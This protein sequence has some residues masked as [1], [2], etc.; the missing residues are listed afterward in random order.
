MHCEGNISLLSRHLTAAS[1]GLVAWRCAGRDGMAQS[2]YLKQA[3]CSKRM[4]CQEEAS[5][6]NRNHSRD[7]TTKWRVEKFALPLGTPP[8][9]SRCPL[10]RDPRRP[11][12]GPGWIQSREAESVVGKVCIRPVT[13]ERLVPNLGEGQGRHLQHGIGPCTCPP[14]QP[15]PECANPSI[16]LS[17]TPTFKEIFFGRKPAG[18]LLSI[19][20]DFVW[21]KPPTFKGIVFGGSKNLSAGFLF[22]LRRREAT[23][24]QGSAAYCF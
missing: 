14:S 22:C 2:N 19:R 10:S 18:K 3:N 4:P 20:L 9:Y 8:R 1:L 7:G 23:A 5:L 21:D 12:L 6:I 24:P 16:S 15:C 11:C 13:G 17:N